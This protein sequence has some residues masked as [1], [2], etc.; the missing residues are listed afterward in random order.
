MRRRYHRISNMYYC[1]LI[2]Y[3]SVYSYLE[4]CSDLKILCCRRIYYD[5]TFMYQ[6]VNMY[7]KPF[8]RRMNYSTEDKII[9]LCLSCLYQNISI[10]R[11][12]QYSIYHAQNIIFCIK[13]V[14]FVFRLI[15]CILSPRL[16]TVHDTIVYICQTNT[17][18]KRRLLWEVISNPP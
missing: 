8:I 2:L 15:C 11:N 14:V 1:F 16:D 3:S 7:G 9:I 17:N 5:L 10:Y 18:H 6:V 12:H 4:C 13:L